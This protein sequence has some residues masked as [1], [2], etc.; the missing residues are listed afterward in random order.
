MKEFPPFRLDAVN[1]CLWRRVNGTEEQCILPTPKAFSVLRYLLEHAGRLVTQDELLEALWPDTFVQPEVL[2]SHIR[3]IRV[4]LGDDAHNPRFIE[5]LPR[6]GYQ[7]VAPVSDA[8]AAA[9]PSA[10]LPS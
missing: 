2:R 9:E 7:F 8:S 1:Q 5:T 10:A 4:V 6:R 3:D